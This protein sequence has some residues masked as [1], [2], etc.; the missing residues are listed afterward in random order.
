MTESLLGTTL[1]FQSLDLKLPFFTDTLPFG[2]KE[3]KS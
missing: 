2:Q 1:S 3:Q